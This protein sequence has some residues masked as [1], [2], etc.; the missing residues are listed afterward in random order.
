M[1]KWK[2]S[3]LVNRRS[4]AVPKYQ[5]F[6]QD[7]ADAS[8]LSKVKDKHQHCTVKSSLKKQILF[9]VRLYHIYQSEKAAKKNLTDA[10]THINKLKV[11]LFIF[12][13]KN[14]IFVFMRQ[15]QFP[16]PVISVHSALHHHLI[17]N[18]TT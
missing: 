11:Y 17:N 18:A 12:E 15:L 7:H 9:F 2:R 1:S 8:D 13:W 16:Q 3:A 14:C 5:T 6:L 4:A 10:E